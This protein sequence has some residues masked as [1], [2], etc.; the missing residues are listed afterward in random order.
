MHYKASWNSGQALFANRLCCE[1]FDSFREIYKWVKNKSWKWLHVGIVSGPL[2]QSSLD[3]VIDHVKDAVNTGK[4]A[5]GGKFIIGNF[6][7]PTVLR[8]IQ[9]KQK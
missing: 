5:V 3:K 2:R 4:I 1:K 8:Y 6:Y 7:Q 9:L